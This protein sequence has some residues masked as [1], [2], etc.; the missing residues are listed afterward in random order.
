MG[1]ETEQDR[2]KREIFE[3]MSPRRQQKILK[4]GY[5]KWEPFLEPKEP[6]FYRDTEVNRAQSAD[7]MYRRFLQEKRMAQVAGAEP[8]PLEYT[9]GVREVCDRLIRGPQRL[10]KGRSGVLSLDQD[11]GGCGVLGGASFGDG[12]LVLWARTGKEASRLWC[13][14]SCA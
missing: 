4:K 8:L 6:P 11:P 13:S 3:S 1:G 9:E 2:K 14:C 5:D 10:G 12:T 7:E